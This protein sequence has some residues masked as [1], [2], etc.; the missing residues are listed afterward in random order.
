MKIRF[1]FAL[2]LA[3]ASSL[4]LA[5]EPTQAGKDIDAIILKINKLNIVKY[6]TPLLLKKSQMNALMTTLEKCQTK[7]KE[8]IESDA[9]EFKARKIEG[10]ID[11]A[12][13]EA[14]NDGSYPKRE[15]QGKIIAIQDA[16]LL[17]RSIGSR[18]WSSCSSSTPAASRWMSPPCRN[19]SA[20]RRIARASSSRMLRAGSARSRFKGRA[21]RGSSTNCSPVHHWR[22]QPW[23]WRVS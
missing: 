3:L 21:S 7:Q 20:P 11:K 2:C 23:S 18:R 14:L 16:L 22:E 15:L 12:L 19:A 5:Q 8:I 10:E 9:K 13:D 6:I 17:R 4:C 1:V